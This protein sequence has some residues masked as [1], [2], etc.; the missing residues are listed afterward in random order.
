[1]ARCA[2]RGTTGENVV[3]TLRA[4]H[5]AEPP[6]CCSRE[7]CARLIDDNAHSFAARL[8]A[9]RFGCFMKLAGA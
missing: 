8:T 7:P 5:R 6:I 1:M 4:R 3:R 9:L 2:A